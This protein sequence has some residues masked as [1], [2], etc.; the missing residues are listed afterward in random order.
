MLDEAQYTIMGYIKGPVCRGQIALN[1]IE[2]QFWVFF[3]DPDMEQMLYASSAREDN[4]EH[5]VLPAADQSN[6]LPIEIWT[7]YADKQRK[8]LDDKVEFIRTH[9]PEGKEVSLDAIW[10]GDGHNPNAALTIFRHF[11][12]AT[13]VTGLHGPKPE[14]AWVITYSLLERIHYLLVAGFDVYGNLGHQL[15]TRLYMDFLR[16]EGESNFLL[17][18]PLQSA[19][20][21]FLSWYR[22]AED[23]VT[24]YLKVLQKAPLDRNLLNYQS[25]DHKSELFDKLI[26]AL[27]AD[28][29]QRPRGRH[30]LSAL[31]TSE[32]MHLDWLP[33]ITL[34]QVVDAAGS[35]HPYTL[36]PNRAHTNVSSLLRERARLLPR[37]Q[38]LSVIPGIVGSYPNSFL[39][40]TEQQLPDFIS[41]VGDLE[42]EADYHKL[43]DRYG[44][45]RNSE[46]F[47]AYADWLHAWGQRQHPV[48]AGLLDFNR[49]ENR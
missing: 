27:G 15:N 41:A 46:Y 29:A 26:S 39:R 17:L 37:E 7:N 18:L 32:G 1:A 2:D 12:S 20:K 30:H 49:L 42:S 5:L 47:W 19:E 9:Y 11:D 44:V 48:Q 13:V 40:V 4:I 31:E 24:D 33:E 8:H 28:I 25:N 45:R 34:V 6:A 43:K 38:T 35:S 14:T 10:D 22:G 36:L 21:E 16:M 3:L 23:E